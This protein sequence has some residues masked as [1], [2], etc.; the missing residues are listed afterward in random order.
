MQTSQPSHKGDSNDV[1][2]A[3]EVETKSKT[4]FSS[5]TTAAASMEQRGAINQ[6]SASKTNARLSHS[7]SSWKKSAPN[8][9]HDDANDTG[10]GHHKAPKT[11]GR[12]V[13]GGKGMGEAP[14]RPP[15]HVSPNPSSPE[16]KSNAQQPQ[17]ASV[18]K[19]RGAQR[20]LERV[21]KAKADKLERDEALREPHGNRPEGSD[22]VNRLSNVVS[23]R[24]S[25]G[26]GT[27][28]ND[29]A[30]P[31]QSP[32]LSYSRS[33]SNSPPET[34]GRKAPEG[35]SKPVQRHSDTSKYRRRKNGRGSGTS[36][37]SYT[38][39]IIFSSGHFLDNANLRNN[40][41]E[42]LN[43]RFDA[44]SSSESR[45]VRRHS[46]DRLAHSAAII[47]GSTYE[48]RPSN[49]WFLQQ[50]TASDDDHPIQEQYAEN[51]SH[52]DTAT[53]DDE[54]IA[55]VDDEDDEAEEQDDHL[56]VDEIS[57]LILHER[58]EWMK[59]KEQ[60]LSQLYK[61]KE[62]V[63]DHVTLGKEEVEKLKA[64]KRNDLHGH[65]RAFAQ[66]P[67]SS[68]LDT[69][70]TGIGDFLSLEK[71]ESK[72]KKE[73]WDGSRIQSIWDL[74][75]F[76]EARYESLYDELRSLLRCREQDLRSFSKIRSELKT[77]RDI[78]RELLSM[79][80]N[81]EE[82][83]KSL[84]TDVSSLRN[85][86]TLA[87][88][89]LSES[90]EKV[91]SMQ[92][93][94]RKQ[95]AVLQNHAILLS[96]LKTRGSQATG[97]SSGIF[98]EGK[99]TVHAPRKDGYMYVAK[100]TRDL[101]PILERLYGLRTLA[102][103]H[104]FLPEIPRNLFKW[105]KLMVELMDTDIEGYSV[106]SLLSWFKLDDSVSAFRSEAANV[107]GQSGSRP[108]LRLECNKTMGGTSF[109]VEIMAKDHY[110]SE[111]WE[112]AVVRAAECAQAFRE[113]STA[114]SSVSSGGS[115]L[116]EANLTS[117][118]G[119]VSNDISG[120]VYVRDIKGDV[121]RSGRSIDNAESSEDFAGFLVRDTPPEGDEQVAADDDSS[122]KSTEWRLVLACINSRNYCLELYDVSKRMHLPTK[123]LQVKAETQ[124]RWIRNFYEEAETTR[125]PSVGPGSVAGSDRWQ[126]FQLTHPG[127]GEN[128][129]RSNLLSP[130]T[131]RETYICAVA[132]RQRKD[133]W[134][135]TMTKL[136]CNVIG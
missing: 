120:I 136:G 130:A 115:R 77:Q 27:S 22:V 73:K 67:W 66:Y 99:S 135:E 56:S 4:P 1:R 58:N 33:S 91:N 109:V 28:T 55:D 39:P 85:R 82:F 12:R 48:S 83:E 107:N 103:E 11:S 118:A 9:L 88:R 40:H 79:E 125:M 49:R 32:S 44:P 121:I 51:G 60:L 45:P 20:H 112:N 129:D 2:H 81:R 6:P 59:E 10:E 86:L 74:I 26:A 108:S 16:D 78:T 21:L 96:N 87:E 64:E 75:C 38:S 92:H 36:V 76:F 5:S 93:I 29:L 122:E 8:G 100:V 41:S 69:N 71:T 127:I 90:N 47:G 106:G 54:E 3:D 126:L 43:A 61:R 89:D 70:T 114:F 94:I 133:E 134:L 84:S 132:S 117:A 37:N 31:F 25:A 24:T 116:E 104:G 72:G 52:R 19:I 105:N 128:Q 13:S 65:E 111:F 15:I 63:A 68:A 124:D 131:K 119:D 53:T 62:A 30:S 102:R 98:N 42:E 123:K 34:K 17:S 113:S 50:N 14:Q 35:N 80:Q 46:S 95:H 110:D 23:A 57:Y 97:V 7:A 18:L 101:L